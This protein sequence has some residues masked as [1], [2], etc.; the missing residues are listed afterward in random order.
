MSEQGHNPINGTGEPDRSTTPA[1]SNTNL[2]ADTDHQEA[3]QQR[4]PEPTEKDLDLLLTN[5]QEIIHGYRADKTD[6][7]DHN[8][9]TVS[10]TRRKLSKKTLRQETN[11]EGFRTL[12][13]NCNK[14]DWEGL[15]SSLA[16]V[17]WNK[18]LQNKD[19]DCMMETMSSTSL[20]FTSAKVTYH[21]GKNRDLEEQQYPGTGKLS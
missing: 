10:L 11:E 16:T 1:S 17:E 9:I 13:F 12:N 4:M 6:I 20:Y 18:I 5:N 15:Q 21:K 19:A 14:V 7:S 8:L 3:T 2:D